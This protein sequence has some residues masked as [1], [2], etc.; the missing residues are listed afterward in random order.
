MWRMRNRAEFNR[1]AKRRRDLKEAGQFSEPDG[2]GARVAI[3]MPFVQALVQS[4]RDNFASFE[5]DADALV[6]HLAANDREPVLRMCATV[7]DFES[8]VTDRTIS[9][10]IVRG[11]GTL[12]AVATPKEAGEDSPVVLLDWLHLS[13]MAPHLKLGKFT[14]RT[15]AGVSRVFNAPLPYGVVSSHRNILAAVGK[16]ISLVGLEDPANELIKPITESH[17]LTYEEIKTRFPFQRGPKVPESVP[18]VLYHGARGLRN[19]IVSATSA[20]LAKPY[21]LEQGRR[22]LQPETAPLE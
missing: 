21:E 10:V 16:V 2:P 13:T 12:S 14:M 19:V 11:F 5:Q 8:V 4:D 9:S 15:C 1:A 6:N 22:V 20:S 18:D 3:V 17:E 7:A